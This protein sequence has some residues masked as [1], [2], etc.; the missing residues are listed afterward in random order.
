MLLFG[1]REHLELEWKL[2][3]LAFCTKLSK[4]QK[5]DYLIHF[6]EIVQ[7]LKSESNKIKYFKFCTICANDQI[8]NTKL[9]IKNPKPIYLFILLYLWFAGTGFRPLI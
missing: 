9:S 5:C 1:S 7:N 6:L 3:I 8:C 4:C 2:K